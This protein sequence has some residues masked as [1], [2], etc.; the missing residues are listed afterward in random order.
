MN[1]QL[2]DDQVQKLVMV[3]GAAESVFRDLII[4]NQP[5]SIF[6]QLMTEYADHAGKFRDLITNSYNEQ[7]GE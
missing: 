2:S 6:K 7:R 5:R 4:E 1:L 3:L